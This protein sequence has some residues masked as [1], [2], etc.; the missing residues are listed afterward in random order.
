[1]S[2][3]PTSSHLHAHTGQFFPDFV[4]FCEE[5]ANAGKIVVVSA[6]DGTFERKVGVADGGKVGCRQP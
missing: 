3:K 5:M 4:S 1:M 2:P 6:L